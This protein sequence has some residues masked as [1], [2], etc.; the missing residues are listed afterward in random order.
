MMDR[1]VATAIPYLLLAR[2][3]GWK[4]RNSCTLVLSQ[5]NKEDLPQTL[6]AKPLSASQDAEHSHAPLL[7]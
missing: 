2:N 3:T 7:V 4:K 1:D 6:G 5:R